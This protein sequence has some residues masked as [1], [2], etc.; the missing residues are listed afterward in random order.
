MNPCLRRPASFRSALVLCA[1]LAAASSACKSK[2]RATK[3]GPVVATVGND[4]ITADE[5]KKRLDEVSPF[6]RARYNTTERKKEFLENLVRNELLAQEAEKRGLDQSP[7]VREQMKR[8]MIQ[9]L[10]KQQLDE[11]LTG[12][13][14]S[15]DELKKFYDAHIDD[16]VKPERARVFRLLLVAKQGDAK[17]RAAAKK[18]AQALLKDVEDRE[19]NGDGNAFQAVVMKS[20]Q[21]SAT[22]AL[23]G[24]LRFLSKEEMAKAFSPELADAAF[25]LKNPG[26]KS[27][28]VETPHGV[29]LVKLQVK[30]VALDRKFDES[31]E[32]IRGRMARERRS[33]EYDDFIK[34][35]RD[36]G[37]V[38]IDEAELAKVSGD[39]PANMQP[40]VNGMPMRPG[41]PAQAPVPPAGAAPAASKVSGN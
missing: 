32:S 40:G 14:I 22:K 16:F 39:L 2:G 20:S 31:K 25:A 41:V 5:F 26:E 18:Q 30:T 15:D 29:E 11:R 9:E 4:T 35:L 27:Q 28:P 10:L 38:K 6:L 13:D 37:N 1:A 21:D 34:K 36:N 17:A 3:S 24:D 33:R 8:A 23:G 19:K 7:A 12:A